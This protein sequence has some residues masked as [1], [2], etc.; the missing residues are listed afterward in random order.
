MTG[1]TGR[2]FYVSRHFDGSAYL[3]SVAVLP[4]P[5]P[6]EGNYTF[7]TTILMSRAK[8]RA[9][10]LPVRALRPVPKASV[11]HNERDLAM[12]TVAGL[13]PRNVA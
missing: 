4:S 10:T 5:P 8:K 3:H 9:Q 2:H 7:T 6:K 12:C 13:E 11:V 1:F